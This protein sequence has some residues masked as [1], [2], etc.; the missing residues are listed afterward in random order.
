MVLMNFLYMGYEL[1]LDWYKEIYKDLD[2]EVFCKGCF[3]IL[4]KGMEMGDYFWNNIWN[5]YVCIIGVDE[6]VGWIIEVFK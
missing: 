2:V 5:Y 3:D 1:V 6:N 4:V